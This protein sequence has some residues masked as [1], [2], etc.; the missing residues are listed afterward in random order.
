MLIS[1]LP[2]LLGNRLRSLAAASAISSELNTPLVINWLQTSDFE[3]NY[4]DVFEPFYRTATTE[5]VIL[6][7][8]ENG[9]DLYTEIQNWHGWKQES[10][11]G[12]PLLAWLAMFYKPNQVSHLERAASSKNL[13]LYT[14]DFHRN[15]SLDVQLTALR[16]LKLIYKIK[17]RVSTMLNELQIRGLPSVHARGSDFTTYVD[18]KTDWFNYYRGM[19]LE[20]IPHESNFFLTSEDFHLKER[21][22]EE[23]SSRI[24]V[25]DISS[26]E[27]KPQI[28]PLLPN[29]TSTADSIVDLYLLSCTNLVVFH[30]HSSYA[31]LARILNGVI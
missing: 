8:L 26:Y 20:R 3:L 7:G 28:T 16:N 4:E 12:R 17:S 30:P 2:Q 1:Y 6:I 18:D 14:N 13:L 31:Q 29:T 5:E 25:R 27:T 10:E 23:F 11:N 22:T 9:L 24:I 19:I 15:F 21:L